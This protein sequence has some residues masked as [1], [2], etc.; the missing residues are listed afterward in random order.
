MTRMLLVISLVFLMGCHCTT[1]QLFV[2]KD[3]HTE[4]RT[5]PVPADTRTRISI[6]WDGAKWEVH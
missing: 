2:E 3:W 4:G 6:N 1:V 5:Y